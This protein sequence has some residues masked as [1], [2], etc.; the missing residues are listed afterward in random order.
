MSVACATATPVPLSP[1]CFAGGPAGRARAANAALMRELS[2]NSLIRHQNNK[3][4]H[5]E[6]I[7]K[8][9]NIEVISKGHGIR[10]LKRINK[11]HGKGNWRKLKS[12]ATI[13]LNL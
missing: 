6:I 8:I 13:K 9:E 10:D 12:I 11:M 3:Y 5:F 2:D 1:F 4:I 7:G